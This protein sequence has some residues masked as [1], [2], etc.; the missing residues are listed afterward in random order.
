MNRFHRSNMPERLRL[1]C[2]LDEKEVGKLVLTQAKLSHLA[3]TNP[4]LMWELITNAVNQVHNRLGEQQLSV[5]DVTNA[6]EELK[7]RFAR[8]FEICGEDDEED[9]EDD[10]EL[11]PV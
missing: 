6:V 4:A 2:G 1:I 7:V 8:F 5:N 10:T 3:N 9:E 11:N